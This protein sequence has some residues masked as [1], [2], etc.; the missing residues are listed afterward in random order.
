MMVDYDFSSI[1]L[2]FLYIYISVTTENVNVTSTDIV[3]DNGSKLCSMVNPN[4]TC[5]H[6]F[7]TSGFVKEIMDITQKMF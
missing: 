7:A 6:R 2:T 3:G 5:S 4:L 1:M